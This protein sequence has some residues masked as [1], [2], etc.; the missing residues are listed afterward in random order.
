MNLSSTLNI[1]LLLIGIIF[2]SC[3]K[4]AD[5]I[6]PQIHFTQVAGLP[7]GGRASAVAFTINDKG[8][9]ALGRSKS[10]SEYLKD[11]WEFNPTENRW[12]QKEDFPGKARVKAVAASVNGKAYVGLGFEEVPVYQGIGYLNDF[13][14]YNPKSDKWSK[15]ADFPG[16]STNGCICFVYDNNIYVGF[17]FN[18]IGFTKEM[19]KYSPQDDTWKNITEFNGDARVGGVVTTNGKRV[20]FG[21]GFNTKN[22]NDWWE[23]YP[24]TNSWK[25]LKSMPD[26]GRVNGVALCVKDRFFVSSGRLFGGELSTGKLYTDIS[27]YDPTLNVWYYCGTVPGKGRENAI[28]FTINNKGYIGFGETTT[29]ILNDFWCFEP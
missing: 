29:E 5:Y 8:Y 20:F 24:D 17:G 25:R 4:Y 12:T 11:C 13:W 14:E 2:L 23:Y 26:K 27:E 9:I 7:D 10:G 16:T 19:W 1:L 21:T 3:D 22:Y 18:G 15:K 6:N 28:S